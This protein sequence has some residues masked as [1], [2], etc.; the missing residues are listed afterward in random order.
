MLVEEGMDEVPLA[1]GSIAEAPTLLID[2]AILQI[3]SRRIHW[4]QY[5]DRKDQS[6]NLRFTG[7][8]FP[9]TFM[10]YGL[11]RWSAVAPGV[12]R[13]GKLGWVNDQGKP[14]R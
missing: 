8:K 7:R 1:E 4:K 5:E 14:E 3:A 12:G 10:E 13:F 11:R 6:V 2:E 9:D